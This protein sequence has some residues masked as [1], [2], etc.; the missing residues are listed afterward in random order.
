MS[1]FTRSILAVLVAFVAASSVA[2]QTQTASTTAS[3]SV[4]AHLTLTATQAMVLGSPSGN[5]AGSGLFRHMGRYG[6]EFNPGIA[7]QFGTSR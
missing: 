1:R 2:A 5:F 3:T 4:I 7:E 6:A